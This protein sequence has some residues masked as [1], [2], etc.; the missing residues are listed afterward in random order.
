VL[1]GVAIAC[2]LFAT[3]VSAQITTGSVTGVVTDAQSGVIPGASVVLISETQG[4]R[5]AAVVTSADGTY[6]MPNVKADTY[7]VEVTMPSFKVLTRKGVRVSGGDRVRVETLVL[8]VGGQ[9]ENVMV[10][11]EAPVIQAAS[12]ERSGV[13]QSVQLQNLPSGTGHNFTEFLNLIPGVTATNATANRIGGSGQTNFMIDGISAMDTG[14]NGLMGGLNLPVDQVAEVKVITSGYNAEYGRSIGLQVSAVTKS[15]TNQFRGSVYDYE[16]HSDWNSN[17]W[18]NKQNG[19]PKNVSDQRDWGYTIGGP[20]GKPGGNNKLFFFYTSEYRPRLSA[21]NTNNFRFPTA[22]E[23]RGD[24]S[25]TVDNN[26]NL[27]NLIYDPSNAAGLPKSSCTSTVQTACFADGGELGRIPISRLYGPGIA[28]LNQY[29]LPNCPS[30]DCPNW[31]PTSSYNYSALSPREATL[32]FSPTYRVDYQLSSNFRVTGKWSG[33]TSRVQP[34]FN[35]LPGFNDTI[36]KFPLSFNTSATVNYSFSPT[37]F[38][39]VTFGVNQNRLGSPN[40]NDPS[41]R[42]NVVCPADLKAAIANCTLGAIAFPF[43]GDIAVNEKYYEFKAL[44]EIG[45]PF[46]VGNTFQMPP[47]LNWAVNGTTSRLG[48]NT[49]PSLNFPGFMN[50][51][52]TQDFNISLTKVLD[53]HTLKAGFYINHSYKAQNFGAG[54]NGAPSFQGALN[55]GQDTN[56]PLDSGFGYS[57]AALG[58]FSSYGQQSAFIEG[59]FLYDNV[60]WYVQDNWKVSKKLTLDYGVRFVHQTPQYDQFNQVSTFRPE[61]WNLSKAPYLYVPGCVGNTATCAGANRVAKDPRTGALLGAGSSSLVG[62]V[63]LGSGDGANGLT[64]A[65]NGIANTGYVWPWLGVAPRLGVAYDLSGQ[66]KVV[67]RGSIGVFFD[68]P[69]GNSVFSTVGNPPVATSTQAQWG[70]L[71]TLQNAQYSFGPVPIINS[72]EYD[73]KLPKDIQWNGGVQ[74]ALPWSSAVDLEYVG[75]HAYDTLS[76]AGGASSTNINTIDVGT[77]L[78]GG[79]GIDPTSTSGATLNNNLVRAYRGYGNLNLNLGRYYRTFH[80]VQASYNRR[81]SHGWQLGVNWNWAIYDVAN[82]FGGAS[83]NLRIDHNADGTYVVR[84]DQA[85]AQELF[86]DQGDIKHTIKGNFVWQLPMIRSENTIMRAIGLVANDWQLSG[87]FTLDSG[88]PFDV[89]Y[90]YQSGGGTNLTGSPDYNARIII[91]DLGLAGGGCSDDQ[92]SQFNNKMVAATSGTSPVR[93]TVF[94]GPSAGSAGLESGRALFT[95]CGARNLDLAIQRNIKLGGGRT[96]QLRVDVFNALNTVVYTARQGTIQFN[97]PTDL[98]VRNSQYLADGSIDPNRRTPN[99][100]GFGAVS[101]A[102]GLRSVQGQ[103]RFTF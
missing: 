13:I 69:D 58:V 15:G 88:N 22:L 85:K 45:V 24:F 89:G 74:V 49:P 25:K 11:A 12:G 36:Q 93:S 72:F 66:Q 78:P 6:T 51:N 73:S 9:T 76:A 16:R 7:S 99:T 83:P 56:N 10:Q 23:R 70:F 33:T 46:L 84:A 75:H 47:A 61:T 68:R 3:S 55:F 96:L 62:N 8:E 92:Y 97:S 65:G 44:N 39:E 53:R 32:G 57:N 14:N 54:G 77:F 63:I 86:G 48:N 41:N 19:N 101:G 95:G 79:R 50:I 34:N 29:P 42:H 81:F 102:A 103:I 18:A 82:S 38:M 17:S 91:P 21:N 28:L 35:N 20:V 43:T 59:S 87:I 64:Q 31:T 4:T 40:I 52:R 60:E 71:Q 5:S 2:G 80:S 67:F 37:T 94:S 100:A 26:G 27:Y 98:T 1:V 90:S 30:S